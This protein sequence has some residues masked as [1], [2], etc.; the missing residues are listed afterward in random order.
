[1]NMMEI[2]ED[3]PNLLSKIHVLGNKLKSKFGI[4]LV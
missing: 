2:E 4:I 1:M 3:P